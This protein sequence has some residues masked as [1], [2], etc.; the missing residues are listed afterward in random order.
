[1][2]A[3]S[4]LPAEGDRCRLRGKT[5]TGRVAAIRADN[6]WTR[7]EWDADQTGPLVCHL[8]EL[9]KVDG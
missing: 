8:F 9:E 3:P 4:N 5:A 6:R 1:M 7:V 2:S